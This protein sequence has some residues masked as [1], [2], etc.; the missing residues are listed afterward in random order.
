MTPHVAVVEGIALW[1]PR[2]AGWEV[3]R[4]V[5]RGEALAPQAPCTRP[6]PGLLP[7]NER[8]RAP[9]TVALALEV[10]ARA[11]TAA[12]RDA[13]SLRSVFSSTHGD[14]AVTDYMC[15]TLARNPA[16]MSPTRF[17]NSVHNAAAGYWS[18]ASGAT[19]AY[20]ALSAGERS[21]SQGLLEALTE[22]ECDA[23]PVLYVAYDIEARGPLASMVS[24]RD[25]LGAA[26]VLGT[27]GSARARARL[28]WRL[29]EE[30]APRT[31]EVRPEHAALAP[32]NTM[33]PCLALF[34]A[35]AHENFC[36]IAYSVGPRLT[37][38]LDVQPV[39]TTPQPDDAARALDRG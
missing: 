2:L 35:L 36:R 13:G 17:H 34:A 21:F 20:T 30:S 28:R 8:R 3:A 11:C 12:G 22:L 7:P 29:Q 37:L 9:D 5:L 14:L 6:Q 1:T 33:S 26:L 25:L 15:E 39:A 38:E 10:A 18:I 19:P 27:D 4:S 16:S 23:A 24:S 31:S 32:G